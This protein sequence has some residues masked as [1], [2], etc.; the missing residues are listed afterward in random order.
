MHTISSKEFCED[1]KNQGLMHCSNCGTAKYEKNFR[2]SFCLEC[3][4]KDM[5]R[6][7]YALAKEKR[8]EKYKQKSNA[9]DY[10]VYKFI[11]DNNQIIYVGKTIRLPARMVQHFKADSHL[12]DECYDNV[13][14]IFYSSLKTKVEMDIYEIYLIDKFRPQYNIKSLYEQEEI[15]SIVLPELVWKKY[16]NESL[17][18]HEK[19][20]TPNKKTAAVVED[21]RAMVNTLGDSL[22]DIRDRALILI[23]FAAGVR[24]S[25]LVAIMMDDIEFNCDGLTITMQN[26]K[27]DQNGQGN[28][29]SIYYGSHLETCPVRSLQEWLK[30]A[31][32][33]SGPLFRRINRHGQ[34]GERVLGDQSVAL[35]VKKLAK[36]AG[37]DEKKYSGDSLRSGLIT[38]AANRGLNVGL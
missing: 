28:K 35:I 30:A 10:V 16:H 20:T 19:N 13:K 22:I 6:N 25:E 9:N 5:D 32:I 1:L 2:G 38:T 18:L 24:R 12:T 26:S 21:I 37:L 7:Y 23:G 17:S 34:V 36:A 4:S 29:K 11:D 8:A 27:T 14:Y 3:S 15:S 31:K 33:E